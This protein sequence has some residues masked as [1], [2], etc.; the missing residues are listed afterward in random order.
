MDYLGFIWTSV[1]V[2]GEL[3]GVFLVESGDK[4][5][6]SVFRVEEVGGGG[7]L[8][9]CEKLGWSLWEDWLWLCERKV[10][11]MEKITGG[12]QRRGRHDIVLWKGGEGGVYV[13]YPSFPPLLVNMCKDDIYIG[14]FLLVSPMLSEAD[15]EERHQSWNF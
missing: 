11:S 15:L 7:G 13:M 2:I 9:L 14:F 4:L 3:W 5:G 1:C 12:N 8:D 6:N 10:G